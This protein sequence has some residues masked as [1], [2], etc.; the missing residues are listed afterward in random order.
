[1]YCQ[2]QSE[3]HS[4]FDCQ[5]S[6]RGLT[7]GIFNGLTSCPC[8]SDDFSDAGSSE[9]NEVRARMELADLRRQVLFLQGQLEDREKTV[10]QLRE[11]MLKLAADNY[12]ANSAPASTVSS[13]MQD[14]VQAMCNAATQTERVRK[15]KFYICRLFLY[16]L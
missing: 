12:H 14:D 8:P 4:P 11:Q 10:Q 16:L 3:T 2:F 13:Q 7:N 9:D 15:L 5:S 1:M 6:I